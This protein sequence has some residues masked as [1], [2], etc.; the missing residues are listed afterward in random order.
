MLKTESSI[1]RL[2]HADLFAGV[3]CKPVDEF[4]KSLGEG[5]ETR[6][7]V[8]GDAVR[9]CDA[10]AGKDPGFVNVQS[11][12][13]F[14]ENFEHNSPPKELQGRQGLVIRQNRVDLKEISLRAAVCANR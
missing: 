13:V 7:L 5:R 12:A 6:L 9:V 1:Y 14:T 2:T 11:T 4:P 10:N 8:M 3:K